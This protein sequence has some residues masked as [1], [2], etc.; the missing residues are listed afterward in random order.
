MPHKGFIFEMRGCILLPVHDGLVLSQLTECLR[1]ILRDTAASEFHMFIAVDGYVHKSIYEALEAYLARRTGNIIWLSKQADLGAVLAA[2][3]DFVV[4][5]DFVVR[6]DGD[7]VWLPQRGR[8]ILTDL[9]T[10]GC[11]APAVLYS[12]VLESE[13]PASFS[14]PTD[15]E[16]TRRLAVEQVDWRSLSFRCPIP[17]VS[18]VF[19]LPKQMS[20]WYTGGRYEDWS[21]WIRLFSTSSVAFRK[22]NEPTVSVRT[23]EAQWQRRRGGKFF[24]VELRFAVAIRKFFPLN[25][26]VLFII[27]S[28]VRSCLRLLPSVALK[29]FYKVL[30]WRK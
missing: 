26:R 14:N 19:V 15:F 16:Y 6:M 11:H 4:P 28:G 25:W 29:T 12:D 21:L 18:A 5:Y 1:S 10:Y 22:L 3:K 30:P 17:H 2:C 24:I 20:V 7:D 13:N 23:D 8:Q 9:L 27:S